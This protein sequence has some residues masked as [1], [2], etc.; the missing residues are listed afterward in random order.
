[1]RRTAVVIDREYLKHDPGPGHP[2]RPE[3]IQSL[4]ELARELDRSRYEIAA[5]RVALREE[6]E[7][8]HPKEYVDLI[9]ATSKANRYALDGDTVT[10][11]DSFGVGLL[12]VGGFLELI[13]GVAAGNFA[14]GFALVRPPGHHALP[15]RAMGFCLFNTVAI[16][17]L[18][19]IRRHGAKRVLIADWD[20]HHGNGTQDIF[21]GDPSVLYVS[22]HQ[23]PFY[24][25]TGAATEVGQGMGAGFTVNVPLPAGSADA[26]YVRAFQEI[27]IPIADKFAPDWVLVSAGFD[28]HRRDPLAGMAMTEDGFATLASLLLEVAAKHAGGRIA[29]VLEG[30]YDLLA[31]RNSAVAVLEALASERKGD[32]SPAVAGEPVQRVIHRVRAIQERYW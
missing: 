10:S 30:G 26:E 23:Y 8:C 1:M 32:I 6:I 4:L 7:R 2:E 16:G 29:L 9:A 21:Y 20:V 13:D 18:H 24:P 31:L 17:A 12:A 27:V 19:A 25:G 15:A 28:P 22:T 5:P 3:R 11:R 14:N